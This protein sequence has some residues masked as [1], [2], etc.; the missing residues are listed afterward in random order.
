VKEWI[1]E[2]LVRGYLDPRL[3]LKIKAWTL[4]TQARDLGYQSKALAQL[5][6]WDG[7][8]SPS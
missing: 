8:S 6:A 2:I 7:E 3:P 5:P 1:E 4:D